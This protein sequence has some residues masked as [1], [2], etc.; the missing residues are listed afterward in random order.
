MNADTGQSSVVAAFIA[1][2]VGFSKFD[3]YDLRRLDVD[4]SDDV[5]A[6]IDT[7]RWRKA[8]LAD[9]VPDGWS[10]AHAI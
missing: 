8:H 10:R 9:L 6:C 1:S 2:V 7:I 5:M 3:L 4:I